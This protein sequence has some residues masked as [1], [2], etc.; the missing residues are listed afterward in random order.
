[1]K[2]RTSLIL[3]IYFIIFL[4]NGNSF[5]QSFEYISPKE[6]SKYVSLSTN[7][8]LRSG[9]FI[10]HSSLSQNEFVVE[11]SKSGYHSGVVKLSDDNKTILFFPDLKFTADEIVTVTIKPGIKTVSGKNFSQK[12]FQFQTTTLLTP[13]NSE[14][15]IYSTD[16]QEGGQNNYITHNQQFT[17]SAA[18][19][20]LPARFPVLT[21]DTTNNPYNGKIF[22][23][24]K[25]S[26]FNAPYDS[27]LIIADNDGSIIKYKKFGT[28]ESNFKI[29]PDGR[30]ATSE[31]GRHIVL[32]TTLT[33]VDTFKCGNGYN[34]DS[35]D[36]LLLPN[37]HSVLFASDPQPMD[38]SQIVPGGRPD[39]TV[40]GAVIQE[41]DASKNVVFQW[42]SFDYIDVTATYYDLT[43]KNIPYIHGN[44]LEID[45]EGNIL[46]SMRYTSS[47]VKVNRKTGDVDWVL[48][49]KQNQFNF[50]NEHAANSPTYF[51]NQHN[52]SVLPD[53]NILLFDNGD[54]HPTLYSRGV[55]YQLNEQDSTAT[56][57][58]EYDHSK[59]IYTSSGGSVQRLPNG[60]TILGWSRPGNQNYHP[61]FTEVHDTTVVLEMSFPSGQ[62]SYRAY[63]F[64][65]SDQA[66]ATSYTIF[67]PQE[68]NTYPNPLST[69]DTIGIYTTFTTLNADGYSEVGVYRNNYSPENPTFS[70]DVPII[71]SHY[72]SIVNNQGVNS[73]SGE[74]KIQL[75]YFPN[76]TDPV[77][78]IVYVRRDSSGQFT[79]LPTSYDSSYMFQTKNLGKVLIVQVDSTFGDF[80]FGIPLNI[81]TA[82]VPVP[83]SPTNGGF[84]NGTS[85]IDFRW[86]TRG[87][88]QSYH[89]QVAT[90][91]AFTNLVTDK[92]NLTETIYKE[93][94][95]NND[96]LYYWRVNN[97]NSSGTSS[98]SEIFNFKTTS[99]YIKIINPN[100]G[101]TVIKD[102]TYI[103]RWE[104]NISDKVNIILMR[105]DTLFTSIGKSIVS[106]T[107]AYLWNVPDS[108]QADSTYKIKITSI[109]DSTLS[110]TSTNSFI[111]KAKTT[112]GVKNENIIAKEYKLYNNYPNPFN[113][114]T[115]IKFDIKESGLV[116]LK[117]YDILGREVRTLLDEEKP[118]G[119]YK[120]N[121]DAANLPSGIYLYRI[122]SGNFNSVK[123]MI[124]LR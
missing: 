107:N 16:E 91:S 85:P 47:I 70:N 4:L 73:Y 65:W 2:N 9:E 78:T 38:M 111:I 81:D 21:V 18:T 98:W 34:A 108:L 82:Y 69:T 105:S 88:V 86:G 122:Q 63:K 64:P 117:I 74:I 51:S 39:A 15:L 118:A 12:I 11:G 52:V 13:I 90:D 87:T 113:P 50:I 44:A 33:P 26:V 28:P 119:S 124:L 95:I 71:A 29:L 116:S 54:Q 53:G 37:G 106:A 59:T 56:M 36:F 89:F 76:V 32:D 10:D 92:T 79:P 96:T 66:I 6:N 40:V 22:I 7:L 49:G 45:K 104:D 123:K 72:F 68:G 8:I 31:N 84:V 58:W 112:T 97:T 25:P 57:V 83:F 35:H 60:N 14:N 55:E 100:G 120:I 27:Y 114:S 48:G 24:N 109:D 1:M 62:F 3:F 43:Q 61:V 67:D 102:S 23:A 75:Q 103:V 99:P 101:E 110:S 19:D 121:F 42:R 94:T 115:T 20:T 46:F 77:K 17:Q 93:S 80:I 30:L 5:S 41:L